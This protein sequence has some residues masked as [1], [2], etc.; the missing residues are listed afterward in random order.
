MGT[1]RRFNGAA[2]FQ[3]RKL[4]LGRGLF[5]LGVAIRRVVAQLDDALVEDGGEELAEPIRVIVGG[6]RALGADAA[7]QRREARLHPLGEAGGDLVERR[8][9]VSL[10]RRAAIA[11]EDGLG[12]VERHELALGEVRRRDGDG[13]AG[14]PVAVR[15]AVVDHRRVQA[16]AKE[17]QVALDGARAGVEIVGEASEGMA[18]S[19]TQHAVEVDDRLDQAAGATTKRRVPRPEGAAAGRGSAVRAAPRRAT[20]LAGGIGAVISG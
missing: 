10:E 12:D 7:R 11:G 9:E 2:A 4:S 3:P 6:E 1:P 16:I 15:P 8:L 18:G 14:V 20:R 13:V 17:L 19:G 5:A